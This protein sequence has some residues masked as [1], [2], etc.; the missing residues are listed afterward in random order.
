MSSAHRDGDRW[1]LSGWIV[2][3]VFGL[4]LGLGVGG[5]N[6]YIVMS[7]MLADIA[8]LATVREVRKQRRTHDHQ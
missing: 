4:G 3:A 8:Y 1:F 2:G 5:A 7:L 6:P